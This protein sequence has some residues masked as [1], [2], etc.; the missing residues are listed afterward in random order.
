MRLLRIEDSVGAD[1]P[2]YAILSHT[3]GEGHEE[4]SLRDITKG[5]DKG[6]NK[7][8]YRKLTFCGNQSLRDGLRFFWVDTCCINKSNSEELQEAINSMFRWS[9]KA[10]KCY[11]YLSDVSVTC[12]DRKRAFQNGRW[13]KR[14]WTLQELLAPVAVEFF[15]TEGERL[16]DRITLLREIY[17]ATGI[18]PQAV[19]GSPLH[20]F[21]D[22]TRLSWVEKRSTKREEDKA[23]SL[24]GIFEV[25]M[26]I[27][28]GE[29]KENVFR[30]LREEINKTSKDQVRH[31]TVPNIVPL[32]GKQFFSGQ[33]TQLDQDR[34]FRFNVQQ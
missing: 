31:Q 32:Q 20:Q 34:P 33:K 27:I 26:P 1:T 14:G 28:Y 3:W 17:D 30:C 19:Q 15:S 29:G 11:A 22:E 7:I 16:R 25:H 8:G 12:L 23:Y 9:S 4:V 18:S 5:L 10:E 24:L 2:P 21:S 6:K 13:L